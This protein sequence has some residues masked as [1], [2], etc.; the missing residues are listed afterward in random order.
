MKRETLYSTTPFPTT[1]VPEIVEKLVHRG[2]TF[3]YPTNFPA[4]EVFNASV[5]AL[6]TRTYLAS[7]L[8]FS[9][10]GLSAATIYQIPTAN[11]PLRLDLVYLD[12]KPHS[13]TKVGSMGGKGGIDVYRTNRTYPAESR[14]FVNGLPVLAVPFLLAEYLS[15]DSLSQALILGDALCRL[16]LRLTDHFLSDKQIEA[17]QML[18]LEVTEIAKK[19][20]DFEAEKQ[21]LKH[22]SLINP[23]AESPL[24]SQ[25]RA[26]LYSAG[27][28]Q[29]I[30]QLPISVHEKTYRGDIF[31]PILNTIVECDGSG[32]YAL[33]PAKEAESAR[34]TEIEKQVLR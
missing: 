27:L 23:L 30:L 31:L 4:W 28:N 10:S 6:A 33:D 5:L 17:F 7:K 9:F 25:V 32:K 34:Q 8:E 22:L 14:T 15:T 20:F 1:E 18:R 24:E 13:N 12:D 19:Y 26:Y 16:H 21:I 29:V 3:V 11:L 2:K